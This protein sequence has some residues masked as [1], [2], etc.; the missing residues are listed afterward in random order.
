[1]PRRFRTPSVWSTGVAVSIP[2]GS[3]PGACSTCGHTL[4]VGLPMEANQDFQSC[5][6]VPHASQPCMARKTSLAPENWPA[7]TARAAMRLDA[8]VDPHTPPHIAAWTEGSRGPGL[9]KATASVSS[10]SACS[11]VGGS[12]R[13]SRKSISLHRALPSISP[14]TSKPRQYAA[15]AANGLLASG[16][17]RQILVRTVPRSIFSVIF[18]FN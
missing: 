4:P 12:S 15:F 14:Y 18:I 16:S 7:P 6:S 8:A 9:A 10:T 5:K 3:K 17:S 11:C 13:N 2:S 1:M